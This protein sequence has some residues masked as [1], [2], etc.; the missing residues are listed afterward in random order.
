MNT[1]GYMNIVS[2]AR[3]PGANDLREREGSRAKAASEDE[4]LLL[5]CGLQI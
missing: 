3:C 5:P 2:R 1:V 4:R